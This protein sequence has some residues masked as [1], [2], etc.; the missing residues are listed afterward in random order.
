MAPSWDLVMPP[1]ITPILQNKREPKNKNR[2]IVSG[3]MNT[4]SVSIEAI[5]KTIIV[6]NRQIMKIVTECAKSHSVGVRGVVQSF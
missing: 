6:E 5:V 4:K 1:I 3:N 2:T